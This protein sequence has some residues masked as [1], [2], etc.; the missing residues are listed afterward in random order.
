MNDVA[1]W[2]RNAPYADGLHLAGADEI[3]RLQAECD[4][5]VKWWLIAYARLGYVRDRMKP[6]D[7][8]AVQD[9]LEAAIDAAKG[10]A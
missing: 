7:V 1:K 2:L 8:V 4:A 6:E 5:A 10:E 3:D 9:F